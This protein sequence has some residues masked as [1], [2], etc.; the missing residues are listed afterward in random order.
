MVRSLLIR[1]M[2]AGF[3][4]CLLVFAFAKVFGE[5][6]VEGAIAYEESKARTEFAMGVSHQHEMPELVSR[7]VQAGLGLFVGLAVF[8]TAV[9]GLFS[10][11]F[12]YAYGRLGVSVRMGP[13]ALSATMAMLAFIAIVLVPFL[14]YPPNPPSIGD[15]STIGSR[16][17]LFFAMI[18]LSLAAL[19]AA[20]LLARRL[21]HRMGPWNATLAAGAL[22]L[23]LIGAACALLPAVNEVPDAFSASLLWH[24]RVAAF[25]MQAVLWAAL[26]LLFGALVQ[27]LLLPLL[28]P[29]A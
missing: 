8:G 20:V 9:G 23:V 10:L 24:F 6:Q 3:L 21:V 27:P 1:G 18:A 7:Q 16:T 19:V 28:Q 11:V 29:R 14:K 5:P 25:G 2:A 22:Y 15:P 4:S 17:A 12:A 26:G 13:R